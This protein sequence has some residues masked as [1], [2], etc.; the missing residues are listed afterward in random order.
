MEQDE[1]NNG[2]MG[3]G[4]M[5][6]VVSLPQSMALESRSNV[7]M[8]IGCPTIGF[9][10]QYSWAP[11]LNQN[12]EHTVSNF[13]LPTGNWDLDRL[14][15]LLPAQV[16]LRI[17]AMQPPCYEYEDCIA[18]KFTNDGDFTMSSVYKMLLGSQ[19]LVRVNPFP[20][21]WDWQGPQHIHLFLWK[22][23][24]DDL[25]TNLSRV[26]SIAS[27]IFKAFKEGINISG[28][29]N[30]SRSASFRWFPPHDGWM[31]LDSDGAFSSSSV[32]AACGGVIRDHFGA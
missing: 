13:V 9:L 25:L 7:K 27:N 26:M 6:Q 28:H 15:S 14:K 11:T 31:K 2:E 23:T 24:H 8:A 10:K 18:W 21:I 5:D 22:A 16:W 30:N 17:S 1:G 4:Y 19:N 12:L 32:K 29:S 3:L 20:K